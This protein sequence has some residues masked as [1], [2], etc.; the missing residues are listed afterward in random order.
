MKFRVLLWAMGLLMARASRSNPAFRKQLQ[1]KDL[2]FQMQTL[3][4]R[5][6]RHFI[7]KDLRVTSRR[8]LHPQP[9][10]AIAFKDAPYGYAT[11]QAKNKQLAF[12]QGV[13]DKGIQIKGNPALVMWFQG[14][15]KH[16]RSRRPA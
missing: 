7:V 6:A 10:F 4:G 1:D 9:A 3:D 5:V 2:V 16:L 15:M 8:G 14:L 13:Q 12:M 11:L